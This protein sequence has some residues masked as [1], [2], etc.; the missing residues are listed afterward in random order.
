MNLNE[1]L[2]QQTNVHVIDA[3]MPYDRFESLDL[4]IGNPEVTSELVSDSMAFSTFIDHFIDSRKALAAYGGYLEKRQLYKR[5][6]LFNEESEPERDIHIGLDIWA[7]AGTSV[8]AA[9]D[10]KIH[11]FDYNAGKGD[12]GPTIILEHTIE[13]HSFFTLYGHL[14]IESIE[15]I[16][17]GDT[18]QKNQQIGEV[19]DAS[20]NGDYP[21]H[22]HF[23]IISDLEDYFG[24]Y[25]GVCSEDD[26]DYY[27]NNCP[28]PNLLLQIKPTL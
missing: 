17:I 16:E 25:P 28:D 24:D 7:E 26:L 23:Q 13:G 8:L 21:P 6:D 14:S 19:G 9:L 20:V 15:N 27:K 4:S 22:L 5:S 11:S 10:G 18:V 2:L 12:Y 3:T 1:L